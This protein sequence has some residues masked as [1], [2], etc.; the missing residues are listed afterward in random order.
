MYM[1]NARNFVLGTQRNLHFTDLRWGFVLGETQ[2]LDLASGETHIFALLDT[3]ML[4]YQAQ[5]CGV[6][7]LSQRQDLT[8]MV[9]RRSGI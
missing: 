8:P 7:G 2:I 9:L 3:N 1:P 6:G 4:V 5:N